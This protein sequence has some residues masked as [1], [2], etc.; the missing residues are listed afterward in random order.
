MSWVLIELVLRSL[1]G[2]VRRWLRLLRTPRYLVAFVVGVAY[3]GWIIVRPWLMS[4]SNPV[5]SGALAALLPQLQGLVALTLALAATLTWLLLPGRPA[6]R[7]SAAELEILMP[8]PLPR[9]QIIAYAL[10]KEQPALLFGAFLVAVGRPVLLPGAWALLTLASLHVKVCALTKARL[11][12]QPATRAWVVRAVVLAG[13]MAYWLVLLGA[14]RQ[15]WWLDAAHL[16]RTAAPVGLLPGVARAFTTTGPARVLLLPFLLV[17]APLAAPAGA[18]LLA[19]WGACA[20]LVG[21][22][23]FWV[24]HTQVRFEEA[25][26]ARARRRAASR[27][28]RQRRTRLTPA[29]RC[30]VPFTLVPRGRP[31]TAVFWKSLVQVVR[32]PLG[33]VAAG[34]GLVIVA[35]GLAVTWAHDGT[36]VLA[37]TMPVVAILAM[38]ALFA[39]LS[40]RADLRLDLTRLEL[41]RTWPVAA[42]RLVLADVLVPAGVGWMAAAAAAGV[43]TAVDL[44]LRLVPGGASAELA[45][46]LIPIQ[47]LPALGVH[48]AVAVPLAALAGFIVLAALVTLHAAAVNLA[49]VLL[50]GWIP[51]GHDRPRGPAAFGQSLVAGVGM[52]LVLLLGL[53]PAALAVGAVATVQA[54]VGLPFV[55][56]ELP[57]LALVVALPLLAEAAFAVWLAGLRLGRID[58]AAELLNAM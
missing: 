25:T 55:A 56:W 20:L 43:M 45:H 32:W 9:R 51:L 21:L 49:V 22:H 16:G 26:L 35:A 7:L 53:T 1:R 18:M 31:E 37:V 27:D 44:A 34:L 42:G 15:A 58:P 30:R 6:L 8:A 41:V 47:L 19:G 14:V 10:L 38:L 36:V 57:L 5:G 39:P 3:F 40:V 46:G 11:K 12:E 28:P 2:R 48:E 29:A 50:P 33:R 52:M 54:L 13:L 24:V 23:V 4:A 17:T